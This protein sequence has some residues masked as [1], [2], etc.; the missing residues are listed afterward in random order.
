MQLPV[1]YS[2]F[3][4]FTFKIQTDKQVD[5]DINSDVTFLHYII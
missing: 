1:L 3:V 2:L 4:C 5:Q